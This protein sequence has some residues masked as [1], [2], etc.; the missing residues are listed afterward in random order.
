[1]HLQLFGHLCP[2]LHC[3]ALKDEVESFLQSLLVK[4]SVYGKSLFFARGDVGELLEHPQD[5]V[6]I[7]FDGVS[8]AVEHRGGGHEIPILALT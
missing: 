3:D 5:F 1:M 2:K 8:Q 6:H 7:R 4:V